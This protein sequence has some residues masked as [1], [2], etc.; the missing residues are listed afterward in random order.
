M[1]KNA[2]KIVVITDRLDAH[3][4][5]VQRH[6]AQP[7]IILDPQTI[8][9]GQEFSYEI[10]KNKLVLTYGDILLND[11][12]AVWYRKPRRIEANQLPL[13]DEIKQFAASAIRNH[14]DMMCDAF[15]DAVW[16]SD[17]P[18]M[19]RAENKGLQLQ[20]AAKLGFNVP[21]T[22]ITSDAK[23]A[24]KFIKAQGVCIT[25]P[26]ASVAPKIDGKYYNFYTS[27]VK[28]EDMPDLRNL[29]LAPSFFQQVIKA[30]YDIRV[31]VV[32]D[33]VFAAK[34]YNTGLK[35]DSPIRDW[36]VGH[37]KGNLQI[38]AFEDFPQALAQLCV[39]H[40]RALG[41]NFGAIDLVADK[42]GEFWFLENNPNGQWA[43]VEHA[44][45]QQIGKAIAELLESGLDILKLAKAQRPSLSVYGGQ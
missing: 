12:T 13:R 7:V 11:V 10:V 40:V 41:L 4:P 43:F 34:I 39:Q 24:A 22:L 35:T 25:K 17:Y 38:E 23:S 31:T 20:I 1:F 45:G 30:A 16:V 27:Y 9:E 15:E 6:L 26:Q 44:T 33:K 8:L 29:H 21:Q 42:N 14:M 5:F 32:G 37:Q 3:L 28:A 2:S 36:R 19:Y 18:S